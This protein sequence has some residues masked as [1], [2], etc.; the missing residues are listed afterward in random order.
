MGFGS[1]PR[2]IVL[3][4]LAAR[5]LQQLEVRRLS[6]VDLFP[7][8]GCLSALRGAIELLGST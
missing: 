8:Q 7:L 4:N 1:P 3:V 6:R 2:V 5:S